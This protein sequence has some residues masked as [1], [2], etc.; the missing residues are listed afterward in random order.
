MFPEKYTSII[1][2]SLQDMHIN[3]IVLHQGVHIHTGNKKSVIEVRVLG[4][5]FQILRNTNDYIP[6]RIAHAHLSGVGI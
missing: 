1:S 2:S 4:K 6:S 3:I 5:Y